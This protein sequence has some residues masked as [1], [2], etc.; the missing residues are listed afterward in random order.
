MVSCDQAKNEPEDI[1]VSD[2][3]FLKSLIEKGLDQDAH[4][5]NRPRP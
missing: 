2:D 3:N 5:L 1:A 4:P